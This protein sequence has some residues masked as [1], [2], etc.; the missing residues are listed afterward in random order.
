[1]NSKKRG[2]GEGTL[3]KTIK[4]TKRP[5]FNPTGECNIC[6]N[7]VDR[8]DCNN[9]QGY[10][11]CEKCKNC[12]TECLK[13]CD[14]FYCQEVWMA[15]ASINGKQKTLPSD[16]KQ[17][18]TAEK[19][20][21]AL[22]KV[23][24]GTYVDKSKVT[25]YQLIID[26]ENE[27]LA[28]NIIKEN[29]YNRNLSTIEHIKNDVIGQI[30][31]QR[32]T[33]EQIKNLLNSKISMSQSEIDKIYQTICAGYRRAE[34]KGIIATMN[35]PM[36]EIDEPTSTK[37]KKEVIAFEIQEQVTLLNYLNEHEDMLVI[38]KKAY[39]DS[40]TIKNLIILAFL[41]GMRIRRIRSFGY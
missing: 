18:R 34:I 23:Q 24:N 41:T 25:L 27:K 33:Q 26:M 38:D 12:K 19:K 17:K 14:R 29:S 9:R 22:G 15:Q 6:K 32:V 10:L 40:K 20:N 7:C 8:T 37:D 5:K 1:M 39:Y 31:L 30:P 21:E 16:K 35:N 3:F 2:N 4:K 28:S 13:Y 36:L 11:K